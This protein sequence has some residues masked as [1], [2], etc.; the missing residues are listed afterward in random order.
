MRFFAAVASATLMPDGRDYDEQCIHRLE[1]HHTVITTEAGDTLVNTRTGDRVELPPC[2]SKAASP[3][4]GYYSDWIVDTVSRHPSIGM[5]ATNWTVPTAP[6]SRGPVPGMSSVYLFNGLETG[7]GHGGTSKGILQPVLSYGKSG[8]IL[9]PLAGW[10]FTAF[11]VTKAGRAYCGKVIEVE[12]GDTL[13][14]RM[15]KSGDTWTIEADAGAK[16]VSSHGVTGEFEATSAYITVEG[17]IIYNCKAL[18]KDDLLFSANVLSDSQGKA[19]EAQWKTEIY[20]KECQP[21]V[22]V[23]GDDVTVSWGPADV[24]V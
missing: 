20:H 24:V 16:G 19:L 3:G 21:A 22:S 13:Q 17:M 12:E 5:M 18:P 9:N 15:T 1:E 6:E 2:D 11:Q 10:R 23:Q 7:T 4:V 14:G 8:C